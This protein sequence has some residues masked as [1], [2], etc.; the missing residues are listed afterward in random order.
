MTATRARDVLVRM[1]GF[2]I[3]AP[4][5][6]EEVLLPASRAAWSDN[7]QLVWNGEAE[8]STVAF[9]RLRPKTAAMALDDGADDRQADA[10]AVTFGRVQC[11]ECSFRIPPIE[12]YAGVSDGD[13]RLRAVVPLGPDEQWRHSGPATRM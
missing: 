3:D 12:I 5:F 9:V 6:S 7:L 4:D 1:T 10:D 13:A 8:R 2:D 11:I